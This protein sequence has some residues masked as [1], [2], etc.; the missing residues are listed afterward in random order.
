[1]WAPFQSAFVAPDTLKIDS[2]VTSPDGRVMALVFKGFE[3]RCGDN[4]RPDTTASAAISGVLVPTLA[5][6][7]G[8]SGTLA[9]VKGHAFAD[10]GARA[11]FQ[12]EFGGGGHFQTFLA[13]TIG[14]PLDQHFEA[15]VF[16]PDGSARVSR[17]AGEP[18]IERMPLNVTLT[19]S[20]TCPGG[21][22][23]AGAWIDSLD[24]SMWTVDDK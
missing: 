16:S 5:S 4:Q 10:N 19:A 8:W 12:I 9:N 18:V 23:H 7:V 21:A 13:P 3:V 22:S 20:V 14:D 17:G 15:S 2:T 1:V 11:T 24:L 6:G